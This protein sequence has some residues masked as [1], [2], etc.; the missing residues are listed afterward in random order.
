MNI[1]IAVTITW[2]VLADS[3]NPSSVNHMLID[4]TAIE[5]AKKE[6]AHMRACRRLLLSIRC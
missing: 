4:M 1:A 6:R 3:P 2:K 5:T